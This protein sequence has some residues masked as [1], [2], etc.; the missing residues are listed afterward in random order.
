MP[1]INIHIKGTNKVIRADENN[2]A[3]MLA[4][5]RQRY[6]PLKQF[7]KDSLGGVSPFAAPVDWKGTLDRYEHKEYASP[8]DGIP[9]AFAQGVYE[10]PGQLVA[11]FDE[12]S[13]WAKVY[14]TIQ[15]KTLQERVDE[16]LGANELGYNPAD[17]KG[18]ETLQGAARLAG[19]IVGDPLNAL[20][21]GM[22]G[23]AGAKQVAS[24]L[25][26]EAGRTSMRNQ[27][28]M[29][30]WQ[31]SPH[32]Y[33][34]RLDPTKIGT[35]EGKQAYGY[36]HYLAESPDVANAYKESLSPGGTVAHSLDR[37]EDALDLEEATGKYIPS[38]IIDNAIRRAGKMGGVDQAISQIDELAPQLLK[39]NNAF[40]DDMLLE[41]EVLSAYRDKIAV[42]DVNTGHLYKFD[43]DD[44][45]IANM[46]DWDAPLSEQPIEVQKI[47]R[48]VAEGYR[49]GSTRKG[50][51]ALEAMIDRN[52]TGGRLYEHLSAQIDGLGTKNYP[53]ASSALMSRG[54]P[55]IKYYDGSSRS[56]GEG[57]RN[58]V[59]FP[60][61][62]SLAEPLERNG[63][64]FKK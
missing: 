6:Q 44:N 63:V 56:A 33:D 59:L 30:T 54:I 16:A 58:F 43:L 64:P 25:A 22:V 7:A 9:E 48:E 52:E 61:G 21:I 49:N 39:A 62:E 34:G 40:G 15:G 8:F 1:Q 14:N 42:T 3:A 53:E 35:G 37:I 28:G 29:I 24:T 45:A 38:Y 19:N 10:A 11:L 32:K 18:S 50:K 46:L 31:G 51:T 13:P 26:D 41:K 4:D 12:F 17:Y 60:G 27:L 57:T 20:P 23:K 2:V 36:G 47:F 5:L 55:G